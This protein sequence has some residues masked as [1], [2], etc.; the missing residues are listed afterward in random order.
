LPYA[1]FIPG[2]LET[3]SVLRALSPADGGKF[4]LAT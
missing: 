2:P 4:L 1:N 3:K